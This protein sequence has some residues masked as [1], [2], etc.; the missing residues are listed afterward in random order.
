MRR[1]AE[2]MASKS[3]RQPR[4]RTQP[5]LV[6]SFVMV[7]RRHR[8]GSPS[9]GNARSGSKRRQP[10]SRSAAC[11]APP[12]GCFA[13][14]RRAAAVESGPRAGRR[15]AKLSGRQDRQLRGFGRSCGMWRRPCFPRRFVRTIRRCHPL[16]PPPCVVTRYHCRLRSPAAIVEACA[17]SYPLFML[18][19]LAFLCSC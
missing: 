2:G 14:G 3:P 13:R 16:V 11:A 5:P 8:R 18:L 6:R 7:R 17:S 1:G 19:W 9:G 10:L 4:V 15:L 12:L